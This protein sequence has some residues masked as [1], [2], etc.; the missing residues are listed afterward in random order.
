MHSLIL[1]A[2][3]RDSRL[4]YQVGHNELA[5]ALRSQVNW[6]TFGTIFNPF[7][8]YLTI[9]PIMQWYN[10][11]R[12]DR[13]I[14]AEIDQRYKQLVTESAASE[15]TKSVLS[16]VLR[17]YI[18]ENPN[19][20]LVDDAFKAAATANI[21]L[22]LFAG[23][24]TTSSTLLFCYYRLAKHPEALSLVQAELDRVLGTGDPSLKI[25]ENPQLVNELTYMTAVIKETLRLHSP[26]SS[27]RVGVRGL[28]LIDDEG[29]AY[30]TEGCNIFT[31]MPALHRNP[32]YWKEPETFIPERWLVGPE[33][34]LYP[35]PGAYRPF[36]MGPRNCIGQTL[37]LMELRI[38]LAMTLREFNI[39]P[40]YDE[41]DK[42]HP[43]NGI[44]HI[45]GN[46]VY[47]AEVGGSGAHPP[48]AFPC[49][50][51]LRT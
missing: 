3:Q 4:N 36:Q 22:F 44:K 28:S 20:R 39:S 38:V 40:A 24:D 41:W 47:P 35:V 19:A 48:D 25:A 30:P 31:L 11:R 13:Y 49:R 18:K 8:R 21:R 12:M 9:R 32:Q 43:T 45:D 23:H 14:R 27:M 29:R 50:V 17:G 10:N 1:A 2:Q 34:E 42:L 26:A 16:L 51:T 37:A 33:D 7:K 46:R 6:T 5:A 15:P